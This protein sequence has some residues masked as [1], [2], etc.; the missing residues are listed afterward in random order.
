MVYLNKKICVI[1]NK[2]IYKLNYY[3][4]KFKKHDLLIK[5]II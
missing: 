5:G 2:L 3:T 4:T 1:I